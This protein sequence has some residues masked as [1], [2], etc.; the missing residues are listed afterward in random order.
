MN[1][2]IKTSIWDMEDAIKGVID[3]RERLDRIRYNIMK[4]LAHIGIEDATFGFSIAEYDGVN[5]VVVDSVPSYDEAT[6]TMTF[7]AQGKALFFIE[8]GAGVFNAGIHPRA[9]EFG[10]IRGAYGLGRGKFE[11][12]AYK[13]EIGNV[14]GAGGQLS[15][16]G[17]VVITRGNNP[18]R[19]MYNVGKSMRAD[20][21]R[22]AREE[23]SRK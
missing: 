7:T 2:V 1:I 21:I 17:K 4:R 15:K 5:D 6:N 8:F 22:I 9:S 12:W 14:L 23:F 3:Y 10:A 20:I 16:D 13:P 18:Q 11:K 19:I